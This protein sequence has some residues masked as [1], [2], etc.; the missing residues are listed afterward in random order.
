MRFRHLTLMLA[1]AIGTMAGAQTGVRVVLYDFEFAVDEGEGRALAGLGVDHD[2]GERN[3][4]GFDLRYDLANSGY[5]AQLRSAYHFSDNRD[6]SVYMGP[7]LGYQRI[8]D[9]DKVTVVPLG[10]R[11]GLR[12]GLER[13]YA[14]LYVGVVANLSA[15]DAVVTRGENAYQLSNTVFVAGLNIGFGWVD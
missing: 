1:L 14:D 4:M 5:C 13:F 8:G 10:M 7:V 6:A 2:F 3:S 12:G 9:E 11:L 15:S